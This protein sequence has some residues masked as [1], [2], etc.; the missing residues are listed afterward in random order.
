MDIRDLS[1]QF[2]GVNEQTMAEA[3]LLS[4]NSRG[5]ILGAVV[6]LELRNSLLDQGLHVQ[7]IKEKWVGEKVHHGDFY[8]SKNGNDWYVFESKGLKSNSEKWAKVWDIPPG[9]GEVLRWIERKKGAA[10]KELVASLSDSEAQALAEVDSPGQVRVLQTHFVSGT[11]GRSG[12]SLAT[13]RKDEFNVVSIDTFIKLGKHRFLFAASDQ[14]EPSSSDS[15]HLKQN[16]LVGLALPEQGMVIGPLKPWV[17]DPSSLL[18]S[19][20]DPVDADL[21]QVDNRAP[22]QRADGVDFIWEET[23]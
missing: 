5:Y 13:P 20:G 18:D 21:M 22:G 9:K 19:L 14:L 12:R 10:W 15:N 7:R 2:F 3:I 16:Y 4:A 11:A 23:D 6:E 17:S 1:E 8:V